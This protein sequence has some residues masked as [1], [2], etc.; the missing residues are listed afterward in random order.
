MEIDPRLGTKDT[1]RRL[2]NEAHKRGIKIMLDAV[3]NHSG[4]FFKPRQDVLEN[5]EKS[6]FKD[7][8][9]IKKFP[10]KECLA[11]EIINGKNLNYKTFGTVYTMPKLNT[12]KR[13]S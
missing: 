10:V 1:F 5:E 12:E 13:K 9:C 11:G 8:F 6:K 4:Y 2:V 3:F 7:W